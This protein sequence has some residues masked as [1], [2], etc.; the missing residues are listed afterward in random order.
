M[1]CPRLVV[2]KA[3]GGVPILDPV[4]RN[5][6]RSAELFARIAIG[7]VVVLTVTYSAL[8]LLEVMVKAAV[9]NVWGSAVGPV[10]L[11]VATIAIGIAVAVDHLWWR[12]RHRARGESSHGSPAR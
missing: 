2:I 10:L 7:T 12:R 6:G 9:V 8:W 1:L 3:C 11:L 4:N 5:V